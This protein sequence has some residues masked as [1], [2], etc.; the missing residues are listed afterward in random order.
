M[1]K[2]AIVS[3][4]KGPVYGQRCGSCGQYWPCATAVA[5]ATEIAINDL[6]DAGGPDGSTLPTSCYEAGP[7]QA[8]GTVA[9]R[10]ESLRALAKAAGIMA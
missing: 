3:N 10:V 7:W 8:P 2:T 9:V 4:H 6:F 5:M 1:T